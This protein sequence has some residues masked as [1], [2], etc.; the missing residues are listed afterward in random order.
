MDSHKWLLMLYELPAKNGAARLSLWRNLKKSGA[1]AL[2]T[3]AY[4]LP[5]SP[6]HHER[7]QWLAEQVRDGG[8]EATLIR[9]TEIEG[10]KDAEIARQFNQARAAD[11]DELVSALNDLPATKAKR[12]IEAPPSGLEKLTRQFEEIRRIDFFDSPRAQDVQMLLERLSRFHVGKS[13]TLPRLRSRD[14]TGRTWLTR[15]RPEIDRVGS[16]WLI[17]KFI[18]PKASFV[19]ANQSSERPDAIPF[20]MFEVEFSH[21]GEDCTFETLVKRFGISD[22]AIK[23][24]AQMV[25][26]A[27]LEDGKFQTC[28]CRGIDQM[29]KGW[30]KAGIS[31]DDLVQRGG[32]CFDGLYRQLQR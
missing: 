26:D 30:A 3:S 25:H 4:L 14:F 27:D 5:D 17:R 22:N 13:K 16:A 12:Q 1:L 29:L 2:K 21:H 23:K 19:F 10:L 24:M 18:D 6:Q 11:Y 9:L 20:D 31:D 28:E 32:Q 7:F 8:G 15:P